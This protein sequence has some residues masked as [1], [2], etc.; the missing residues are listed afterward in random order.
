MSCISLDRQDLDAL[1]AASVPFIR[2][3]G[4][5]KEAW[6]RL[7]VDE[8]DGRVGPWEFRAQFDVICDG[9]W[10]REGEVLYFVTDADGDLRLVG[11]SMSKLNGRWK[12]VP[13]YSSASKQPLGRKALFHT[14]SW[15]AIERGLR[16]SEVPPF[17]V[18]A[19]FRAD[20]E[21]VCHSAKG[22][23]KGCLEIPEVGR[24]RLSYHVETWVCKID[25]RPKPLWN[26]DKVPREYRDT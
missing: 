9:T 24:Q 1:I 16:S 11:Q 14:S 17:T 4:A 25:H 19:I 8:K 18:S 2:I 20:L 26:K 22:A 12:T 5:S 23:L 3:N 15:P 10:R 6:C 13:M 21:K 7:I